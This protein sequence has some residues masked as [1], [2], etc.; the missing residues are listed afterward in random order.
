MEGHPP[1]DARGDVGRLERRLDG[2][3]LLVGAGQDRLLA[4][5][6]GGQL[7]VEDGAADGHRLVVLVGVAGDLRHGAAVAEGE[8]PDAAEVAGV[9]HRVGDLEDRRGGPVVGLDRHHLPV[10]VVL[11]EA[12]DVAGVAAV[13]PV[14]GLVRVADGGERRPAAAPLL[15]QS[16]LERVEVLELVDVEVAEAPALRRPRTPG[17][18]PWRRR[19]A[20]AGR[21]SRRLAA[22]AS[23]GRS[24]GRS[25]RSARARWARA[26]GCGGP[27]RG[28]RRGR[29]PAPSPRPARWPPPPGWCGRAAPRSGPGTAPVGR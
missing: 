15:E 1:A 27:P 14:D 16:V 29:W 7:G 10:G 2:V 26:A 24:R 19:G 28:S 22:A 13:P 18:R 11:E 21:R 17:R 20:T 3:E 6:G 8:E 25:R 12:L 5:R 23:P 4:P 9:E